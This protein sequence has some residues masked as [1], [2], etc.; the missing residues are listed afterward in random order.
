MPSTFIQARAVKLVQLNA[1]VAENS[2]A[3]GD[4]YLHLMENPADRDPAIAR[5]CIGYMTARYVDETGDEAAAEGYATDLVSMAVLPFGTISEIPLPQRGD[6]HSTGAAMV[7]AISARQAL[8]ELVGVDALEIGTE[9][10]RLN[11]AA[12]GRM[13]T[14]QKETMATE[15]GLKKTVAELTPKPEGGT[16]NK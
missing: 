1:L 11:K 14:P 9:M 13:T 15:G 3:Y 12:A 7:S 16:T 6:I 2:E 5:D 10:G 4:R 8:M